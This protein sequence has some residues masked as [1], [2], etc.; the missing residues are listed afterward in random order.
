M[1]IVEWPA[2]VLEA[3][4]SEVTEFDD[5]LRVFVE[6]MHET[7][8][9]SG[10]IGLAANQVNVA[11]RIIT[12][13]I[14]WVEGEADEEV[15]N[16]EP[17]HDK[18]FTFINPRILKK[19][20]KTRGQEG[21]LSFP[22]IFEYIDRASEVVVEAADEKGN[23]FQVHA[24]GLFAICLQHEIDHIDGV[25]FINRMSRLKANLVK[26]KIERRLRE[27]NSGIEEKNNE[28]NNKE[29]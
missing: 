20:G 17:W 16:R 25:V 23:V 24:T 22:E 28:E 19:A 11:K 14:P 18:K 5:E 2:R 3:K 26:K 6:Q 1:T 29:N 8:V 10:G 4:S 27:I 21:C 13:N 15:P 9:K 12:I 7:M